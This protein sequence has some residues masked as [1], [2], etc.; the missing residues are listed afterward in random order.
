MVDSATLREIRRAATAR[1]INLC[2]LQLADERGFDGF[3][4]DE[5]AASAEVSRRTLFNYYPSKIDAVL[6]DGP[7]FDLDA[8]DTFRAGGPHGVLIDD[9]G[10]MVARLLEVKPL[11]RE[12]AT[13]FRR[14]CRSS[15][16]MMTAAHDGL[17]RR[18]ELLAAEIYKREERRIDEIDAAIL[19]QVLVMIFHLALDA[20]IVN[21]DETSLSELFMER[22]RKLRDL[23]ASNPA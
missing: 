6:G 3:T 1:R 11:D 5:L 13:L 10:A 19:V 16:R 15:P 18:A 22:F 23:F 17:S 7:D 2:A 12:L 20:Y 4:M 21:A 8:F 14:L 9:L